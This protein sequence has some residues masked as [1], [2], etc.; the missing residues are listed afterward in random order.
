MKKL[1]LLSTGLALVSASAFSQIAT[2][3]APAQQKVYAPISK[4]QQVQQELQLGNNG[5]VPIKPKQTPHSTQFVME[6]QAGSSNSAYGAS[7]SPRV[8]IFAD[9]TSGRVSLIYRREAN[10]NQLGYSYSTDAGVTW[11]TAQ[12]NLGPLYSIAAAA[13]YPS[14]AI[15][16]SPTG[17]S[18]IVYAAPTLAGTNVP[19][20]GFGYGIHRIGQPFDPS[21]FR[22]FNF[23][24]NDIFIPDDFAKA[25]IDGNS[26]FVSEIPSVS[27]I[28]TDTVFVSRD[29]IGVYKITANAAG[30]NVSLNRSFINLSGMGFVDLQET[31]IAFSRDGQ[32]GYITLAAQDTINWKDFADGKATNSTYNLHV[33]KTTD[34][35]TTWTFLKSIYGTFSPELQPLRTAFGKHLGVIFKDSTVSVKGNLAVWD[36]ANYNQVGIDSLLSTNSFVV[37]QFS[38][39]DTV[40]PAGAYNLFKV[41]KEIIT[42]DTTLVNGV[43]SYTVIFFKGIQYQLWGFNHNA[44]VDA[45][46]NLHIATQMHIGGFRNTN[47]EASGGVITVYGN[48]VVSIRTTDGTTTAGASGTA[49]ASDMVQRLYTFRGYYPAYYPG[50]TDTIGHGDNRIQLSVSPDHK[51]VQYAWSDTDT[52]AEYVFFNGLTESNTHPQPWARAYETTTGKWSRVANLVAVP[53]FDTTINNVNYYIEGDSGYANVGEYHFLHVAPY[54]MPVCVRKADGTV[55]HVLYRTVLLRL[56]G[57]L[58]YT[59]PSSNQSDWIGPVGYFVSDSLGLHNWE[60]GL[61]IDTNVCLTTSITPKVT[62]SKFNVEVFPNPTNGELT[63][64][65]DGLSGLTAEVLD[66][67]GRKVTTQ[68]I[69]KEVETINITN[70]PAGL[71]IVRIQAPDGIITRRIVKE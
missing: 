42:V 58:N 8:P 13:R 46:G 16:N 56:Q 45:N 1:L 41:G 22:Q 18:S 57:T 43:P 34:G 66:V 69:N 27:V 55:N 59:G 62:V 4:K 26:F 14:A 15:Y 71:Y 9:P 49:W 35:G 3:V 40:T 48:F 7:L 52:T 61:P 53:T 68:R 17:S 37:Y 32:V 33:W 39:L 63:L 50:R 2:K 70:Q 10:G 12:Q 6:T 5:A 65:T 31:Q 67:M 28:T 24:A 20:G 64:M 60:L 25:G 30:T 38:Q 11:P 44:A 23:T 29:S 51:I 54:L 19:W 47:L 36:A 21:N